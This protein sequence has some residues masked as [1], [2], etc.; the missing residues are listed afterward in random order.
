MNKD[1]KEQLPHEAT[2]ETTFGFRPDFHGEFGASGAEAGV[3]DFE[4]LSQGTALLVVMRGPNAGSRF[5][6][7]RPVTTAGRLPGSDIFLDDVTVSRRHAEFRLE[8]GGFRIVDVGSLNGTFVNRK[9]VDSAMLAGG[10]EIQIGRFRL[11]F[12]DRPATD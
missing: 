6:L 7:D 11:V 9:P 12:L 8:S 1:N 4:A 2:E 3:W 5:L 10:D